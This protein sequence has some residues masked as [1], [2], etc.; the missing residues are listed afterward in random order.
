MKL[1]FKYRYSIISLL[2]AG[3]VFYYNDAIEPLAEMS[4]S[5]M[6]IIYGLLLVIII[7][8][9]LNLMYI[10]RIGDYVI[11]SLLI[12]VLVYL[13]YLYAL[14]FKELFLLNWDFLGGFTNG[15]LISALRDKII[16][17]LMFAFTVNSLYWV[18]ITVS[19]IKVLER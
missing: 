4:Y 6:W 1:L 11:K 9:V 19:P 5:V 13:T 16:Y 10:F 14:S 15:D 2:L 8:T 17:D 7:M 3:I 18:S 12:L